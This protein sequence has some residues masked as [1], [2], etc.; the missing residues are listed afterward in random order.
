VG[1]R[2]ERIAE[3]AAKIAE[4]SKQVELLTEQLNE[5]VRNSVYEGSGSFSDRESALEENRKL[6]QRGYPIAGLV[7]PGRGVLRR[8]E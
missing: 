5:P 2:D 8:E 6:H 4:L 3:Q 1:E 7:E